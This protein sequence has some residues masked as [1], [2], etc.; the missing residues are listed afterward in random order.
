[1]STIKITAEPGTPFIDITREFDA[2]REL[3]FRAHTEP[4][5]VRQWMGGGAYEMVI[6][7]WEPRDGGGWRYVHR[8]GDGN[9]YA[10]HGVFHGA[11]AVDRMVQTFE[12]EGA[13]GHVSLEAMTLEENDGR[14]IARIHSTFQSVQARDAM[15]ESGMADGMNAGYAKLDALLEQLRAPVA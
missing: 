2:P 5:L 15:V 1:M 7:R 12:F 10:F 11:P 14:T 4:E 8:D 6:D 3:V 13:P 9:E